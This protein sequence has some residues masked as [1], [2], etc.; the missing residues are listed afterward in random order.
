[1]TARRTFFAIFIGALVLWFA[2]P[3]PAQSPSTSLRGTISD[4][5]GAVIASAQVSLV[6]S[7]N[8]FTQ[9]RIADA[10][11]AYQFPQLPPGRY[12]VA[13][14]AAGFARES[15]VAE[16]LI[17]QPATL[18]FSLSIEAA[19][20]TVSVSSQA[21][22]LNSTDATMGNAFDGATILALPV[23]GDIPDLLSL[24]PGVL[25]LGLHNDQSHDSRSGSAEGARSDQNNSTLDGLDN[26][27][28]IRA[29]AFTGVLRSTLDS[30]QEF[31]VSTAGFNAETG[32][33]SG[34][35]INIAT[36]SGTNDFH[37]S[38]YGRTRNLITPANDWFNKQAELAQGL[39]N[40][41]GSLDRNAY[42]ASLGGPIKKNKLFFFTTY[43]GEKI[44][45]NQQMTMIVPTA[46]LRA[47]EIK[48][49]TTAANGATQI[50][51]LSPAQ[52]ASMDPNCSK[53]GTCP[54]GPGVDPYS[55]AAFNQYPL[56]N[57][58]S[59]G[60]GL[61]TASYTW[62]APA[63][64]S[65]NT[66][67]TRLDYSLSSRN[68]LFLRGNLQ[69][70]SSLSPP[71]FPGQ[72][73]SATNTSDSKGIAAGLNSTISPTLMNSLRYSYIRQGYAT[74]GIGQGSYAN[75]YGMSTINAQTRTTIVD[76]PVQ[77]LVDDLTWAHSHHTLQFGA[78]YRLVHNQWDSNAL[79]YNSAVTN[80]YALV[81]AGIVGTGQSFDPTMFG[82]PSVNPNFAGSYNFSMTN[83][84]GLLDYVTA[85][86]NY[87]VAA[88]GQSGSLLPT[89]A[90]IARDFKNNEFEYYVQDSWRIKPNLTI[91]Y[92]LRHTLL[93]TPYEINGQQVAPTTN[94]WN[95]FETRGAQAALGNSVQP[96]ISFAPSGQ[97]R[98][99]QPYWPM[100]W[101]NLAPHVSFAYSPN[102]GLGFWR[103]LL[104]SG[105]NSVLRA[106]YG[107]YYDHYGESIVNLFNEYGSYGLTDSITNPTNVLTPDTSPRYTGINNIPNLTGTPAQTVSY[108]ALSPTNPL[109][110]GFA[111]THGIDN[112]MQTPYSHVVNVS[113]QRQLPSGFVLE[114]AYLGRFGRHQLQQIDLAQPL[115]LVDPKSGQ[116]YFSAATQ[117]SK[118]GY[119]GET[120]VAPIAYFEDM[121][122]SA[123][124]GGM[125]AT[126]NIY[127]TIWKYNL[128]NE[129]GALYALDILCYPACAGQ[130][131]KFW[132]TQFASMYSWASIGDSNYN[133]GQVVL[134]HA[135][136]HG[137]QM[138]LSYTYAKSLDMGS[139]DERT[140]YSSS[141]GSTVGS[142]FSAILN[143]WNPALSYGP[144]DY[145]IRHLIT[146]SWVA[147]L[148]F[149]SGKFIGGNAG[150][151]LNRII[152]GWQLSGVGR[153]T[154]GLPFSIISGA[155]W[156]T[157][158]L[159]KSN[160]IQT[161]PIQTGTYINQNGAPDVFANAAQALASLQ[162]P[163]PGEAGQRNNF[164]G[165]GYFGID[166]R[167]AKTWQLGERV[168]MQ[169]AWDVFNV[170]NSVRFDVNPLNSLQNLTTSGSFGVYGA[171]LTTPRVQQLSL[172][173]SF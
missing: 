23:E 26:N 120:T 127:N 92:G 9:S 60:D 15:K 172:R 142:S 173:V 85:Q 32:R 90:M 124:T 139:D 13:V 144:S 79:S 44:D 108:P 61:N 2:L 86:S 165:N 6:N 126:Q 87:R 102:V 36:K 34:A 100:Q 71:Q 145:D 118:D 105:G 45:E 5:S 77:N 170:T 18:N 111:I 114:A 109:T 22:A 67:I 117:L 63:P 153:W 31:R 82:F 48:Y 50:V 41:P 99:L 73:A 121:F 75:F 93:Q 166:A 130:M 122:P 64:A 154:S 3:A 11:G 134:R 157:N 29:Y 132:A 68:W 147:D 84:A 96:Y 56:P 141:T 28:Q 25:Y 55:L 24:Q 17:G 94:L 51:T 7:A 136:S 156:G 78:N 8:G 47:G 58:Y 110:T 164:R 129:T 76:V 159:E 20:T 81:D 4:P 131:G 119:A 163:Y 169:F 33:S 146:G 1:L 62:S 59:A 21:P 103:K 140:V 101:N 133:G 72:P 19:P 52:I 39:P 138:E 14:H 116:D 49:P 160:M 65:L 148:P 46:S 150:H 115:D 125:S 91:N 80:S 38:V 162:N 53:N 42:G 112:D 97:G 128:G 98:G 161:G 171:T 83:L 66:Y 57:G 106:G 35:Q 151:G 70:D 107:K 137:M 113:W 54:W 95:W 149:G 30:V 135:M 143:A 155:G 16:L 123:A 167:L 74:Y 89:G 40:V 10:G 104:G 69:K 152:G 43:E 168:G 88:N 27:D 12:T 37:G 158:W